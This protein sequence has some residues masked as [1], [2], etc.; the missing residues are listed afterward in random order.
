MLKI[1]S[2]QNDRVRRVRMLQRSARRRRREGLMVA[3]GLRLVREA[4]RSGLALTEAF[5]TE[6]FVTEVPGRALVDALASLM[7]PL[8][9][10]PPQ[11]MAA[12]SDT[13]TPQGILVVLPLPDWPIVE[14]ATLTLVPDSVRDPGNLG[15]MLRAAW[16]MG[17]ERVLIPPGTVDPT[18]PKVVRAG[19]GAHFSLPVHQVSW[20]TVGTLIA[21]SAVWLA[22]AGAGAAY[23]AVNWRQ[24]V[25]LIIGGETEG[26]GAE[27]RA[28]PGSRF[29][30]IPMASGVESLN[31]AVAASILLCEA[32]RQRR[33]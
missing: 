25:A 3:E 16:A 28:L 20:E 7:V 11:V 26:V 17:W 5:Y 15:T 33:M 24:P 30:Y 8:Y 22:Q 12:L 10:V 27:A 23:D 19:M 9:E 31:A 18:N 1:T 6:T 14:D 21:G 2:L 29:V 4:L 32:A 13:E